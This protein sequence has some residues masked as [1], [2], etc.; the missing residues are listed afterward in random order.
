MATMPA[1]LRQGLR[2]G[3][4]RGLVGVV[5]DPLR[6]RRHRELHGDGQPPHRAHRVV[7]VPQLR[8]NHQE[9]RPADGYTV[10]S[11]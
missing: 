6:H 8:R 1:P 9:L 3:V 10:V 5:P 7:R 4:R 2:P 11:H